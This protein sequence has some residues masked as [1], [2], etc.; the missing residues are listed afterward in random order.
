MKKYLALAAALSLLPSFVACNVT[1]DKPNAPVKPSGNGN[2][3]NNHDSQSDNNHG[4]NN[5]GQDDITCGTPDE[6]GYYSACID[7]KDGNPI[8]VNCMNNKLYSVIDCL[9][10]R[11]CISDDYYG[12][13]CTYEVPETDFCS[14]KEQGYYCATIGNDSWLLACSEGEALDDY[15]ENC[16][17]Q[18]GMTCGSI[19]YNGQTASRCKCTTN[20]QCAGNNSMANS[21]GICV[22]DG[23]FCSAECDEG[24]VLAQDYSGYYCAEDDTPAAVRALCVTIGTS[25]DDATCWTDPESGDTW[26]VI[27][28]DGEVNPTYTANC[29]DYGRVCKEVTDNLGSYHT[30]A[31]PD[32]TECEE[33][34][35]CEGTVEGGHF[36]CVIGY[37]V[38]ECNDEE[39]EFN[40]LTGKCEG[41]SA[42]ECTEN[43]DCSYTGGLGTAICN[44]SQKCEVKCVEN[45]S[46]MYNGSDA[47]QCNNNFHEDDGACIANGS[48]TL[49][50]HGPVSFDWTNTGNAATAYTSSYTKTVEEV[51]TI[52]A[53]GRVDLNNNTYAID[54]AGII[55]RGNKTDANPPSEITVTGLT[56]GLSKVT[57][58]TI[59]W[60]GSNAAK[61]IKLLVTPNVGTA[62]TIEVPKDDPLT[63]NR[64]VS[65]DDAQDA[66]SFTIK[67]NHTNNDNRVSINNLRWTDGK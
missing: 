22:K 1:P 9:L 19:T 47:C 42:P 65:F 15:S 27:C 2:Q 33:D 5:P 61:T 24:Y 12:A 28:Y 50:T 17:S 64:S 10:G 60:P 35:D 55:I 3:N 62:K 41:S 45:A 11:V 29:A 37:C 51:V 21:H 40:E 16:S 44:A 53:V 56:K 43:D 34:K 20:E 66:T 31:E 58:D 4:N 46:F 26:Q 59:A 32:D 67:A 48:T 49:T 52:K 6:D 39:A 38:A 63:R 30:C 18:K 14:G 57:L 54:G 8:A 13:Y 23:G 36:V 25:E 7:G